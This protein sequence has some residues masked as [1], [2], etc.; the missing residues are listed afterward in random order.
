[1]AIVRNLMVRAVAD[2]SGLESG[3]NQALGRISSFGSRAENIFKRIGEVGRGIKDVFEVFAGVG[4]AVSELAN[5]AAELDGGMSSL[6][7]TLGQSAVSYM[8]WANGTA[9]SYGIAKMSAVEY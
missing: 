4:E 2:F 9:T 8:D 5:R 6:N 3:M 7:R 1:M